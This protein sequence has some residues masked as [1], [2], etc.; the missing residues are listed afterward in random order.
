ML[1]SVSD[2]SKA[3]FVSTTPSKH[4]YTY[5]HSVNGFS[6]VLTLS[7]LEALKNSS[8]FISFT[9]DLPLKVHTTHTSHFLG[10]S[11]VSGA[12]TAPNDGEDVIIGIVDTG[13]WPESESF[14]DEGMTRV[15]PRWKGRC[16]SGTKFNSSLCNKKLIGAR[17]F[18]KEE[19]SEKS[20]MRPEKVCLAFAEVEEDPETG[21][22]GLL[23]EVK[24]D[25]GLCL[26]PSKAEEEA[27]SRGSPE[28]KLDRVGSEAEEDLDAGYRSWRRD[29]S[30]VKP[31]IPQ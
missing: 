29:R 18:N 26:A 8:G 11:S 10:L 6:A 28:R 17:Y 20:L 9:R 12:W 16:E 1:S 27:G 14:S 5:T 30:E 24:S 23:K 2:T 31:K 21:S 25:I 22:I 3:A 19:K 15:P 7:E 4:L 13:I